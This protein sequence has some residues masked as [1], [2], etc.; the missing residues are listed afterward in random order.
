MAVLTTP[1]RIDNGARGY[2]RLYTYHIYTAVRHQG[3]HP[4][5]L[6]LQK[7]HFHRVT[8]S[9]AHQT[10]G[11]PEPPSTRLTDARATG[12]QGHWIG[13]LTSYHLHHGAWITRATA[14]M[15]HRATD[16]QV[17][18]CQAIIT[19][20]LKPPSTRSQV[21]KLQVL[22][23]PESQT[24]RCQGVKAIGHRLTLTTDTRATILTGA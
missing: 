21:L 15:S 17:P 23:P 18:R 5:T 16:S 3:Y 4:C 6:D 7:P 2:I 1:H 20:V 24:H 22:Q 19:M 11:L 14:P 13:N 10:T 8:E 12:S 9:Q